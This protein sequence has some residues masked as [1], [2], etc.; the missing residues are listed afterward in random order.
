M[1]GGTVHAFSDGLGRGSE[2]VVRL[3]AVPAPSVSD[4]LLNGVVA[5]SPDRAT[6]GVA[7]QG[8]LRILVVDDNRDS[9]HSLALLLET[10]GHVVRTAYDGLTALE[11]VEEFAPDAVVLDI[12]LPRL[13][14]YD[15]ARRIR[16]QP[17]SKPL[18]LVALTGYGHEEN[19]IQAQAAGFDHHLVKPVDLDVLQQLFASHAQAKPKQLIEGS[20]LRR[21]NAC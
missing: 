15:A 13:N 12:G 6:T 21:T 20:R 3:A 5:R 7:A 9:A 4:P 18:L 17:R 8:G 11:V 14:G 1:H 10:Q 16:A 19:R 2:F